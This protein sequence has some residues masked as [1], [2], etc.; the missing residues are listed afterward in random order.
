MGTQ[1]APQSPPVLTGR[2]GELGFKGVGKFTAVTALGSQVY[3]QH[4]CWGRGL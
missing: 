4:K 2:R 1:Q 3:K